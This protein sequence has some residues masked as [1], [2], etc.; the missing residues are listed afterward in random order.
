MRVIK[1][2]HFNHGRPSRRN[3]SFVFVFFFVCVF[4]MFKWYS[5]YDEN[6]RVHIKFYVYILLISLPDQTIHCACEIFYNIKMVF[7][8]SWLGRWIIDKKNMPR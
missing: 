2:C 6:Y 8:L 5:A 1:L 3:V 7:S 4:T